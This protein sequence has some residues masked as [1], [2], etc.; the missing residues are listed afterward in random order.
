MM[1]PTDSVELRRRRSFVVRNS[2]LSGLISIGSFFLVGVF[3]GNQFGFFAAAFSGVCAVAW[4][5]LLLTPPEVMLQLPAS[6]F[7][8]IAPIQA[9]APSCL[10]EVRTTEKPIHPMPAPSPAKS[11]VWDRE[12]DFTL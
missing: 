2:L 6:H 4:A 11:G 5:V 10:C 8:W 7:S 9:R 1:E 3:D 12:L